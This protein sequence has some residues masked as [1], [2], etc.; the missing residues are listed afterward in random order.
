LKKARLSKEKKKLI[1]L[2]GLIPLL[3]TWFWIVTN[4]GTYAAGRS[5]SAEALGEFLSYL[6]LGTVL[7]V[8][9]Y[10][11]LAL[12]AA[13]V[14]N[15]AEQKGRNWQTFFI[16][17]LLFPI[18]TWIAVALVSTDQ[19]TLRDGTKT[20]PLCAEVVKQEAIL[21]KHCG[22]D[23]STYRSSSDTHNRLADNDKSFDPGR[24]SDSEVASPSKAFSNPKNRNSRNLVLVVAALAVVAGITIGSLATSSSQSANENSTGKGDALIEQGD[25]E[26]QTT[27]QSS[28]NENWIPEG[29]ELMGEDIAGKIANHQIDCIDCGGLSWE[30]VTRFGCS[31]GLEVE[32]NFVDD[33]GTVVDTSKDTIPNLDPLEKG[34]VEL[35]TFSQVPNLV[36]DLTEVNCYN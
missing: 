20:C 27:Q 5:W 18:I 19:S 11:L 12:I 1:F 25:D 26:S 4:L 23:L 15:L 29:F 13:I 35:F 3:P 2:I 34:L 30:V 32:A 28:G 6:V 33:Q 9:I 17:S 22:T 16:L 10:G 7:V 14:A 21:C 8:V 36:V 24:S 31:N